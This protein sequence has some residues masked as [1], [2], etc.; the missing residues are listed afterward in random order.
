MEFKLAA[1]LKTNYD[2]S[3]HFYNLK[4]S[5]STLNCRSVLEIRRKKIVCELP[6]IVVIM[7]NPGSSV[8]LNKL[9]EPKT[10]SKEAY[11][12]LKKKEIVPTRPDNAQYQIMRLIEKNNWNFVRIL[13][14]S[15]LRNGN[16][17]KFQ[18]EFR[19]ALK[20][21]NTSPHCITHIERKR[22]LIDSTESKSNKIIAAWGEI[23]EL[24]ESAESILR[25]DKIIIGLRKGETSNFRYA[26]PYMKTQKVEWLIEIQKEINKN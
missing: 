16:S 19:N 13:N 12:K 1:E 21:D 8:P 18:T 2:I 24:N 5:N 20:L 25:M 15:D 26:S 17:G 6:D 10:F 14:L 3:G 23:A 7:M 11:I 9:Y 22:E 4:L